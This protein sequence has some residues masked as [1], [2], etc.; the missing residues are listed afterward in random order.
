MIL[1]QSQ[2]LFV[3]VGLRLDV[4]IVR[5]WGERG[6]FLGME[7]ARSSGCQGLSATTDSAFRQFVSVSRSEQ[8]F[9]SMRS[10]LWLVSLS[11]A[12][13]DTECGFD[14]GVIAQLALQYRS[15]PT[16]FFNN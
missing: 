2:Q 15:R 11:S 12:D 7:S 5:A 3:V 6:V 10:Y 13:F 16:F 8:V 1:H 14:L 4:K 9:Q